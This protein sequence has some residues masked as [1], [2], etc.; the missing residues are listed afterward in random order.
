[1][2]KVFLDN[3]YQ[4]S[5]ITKVVPI[6]GNQLLFEDT[7]AYSFSGGQESELTFVLG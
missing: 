2:R 4:H 5:L 7:I 3:P 6:D 1:M